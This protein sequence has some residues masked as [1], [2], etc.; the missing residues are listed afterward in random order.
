MNSWLRRSEDF[1]Y[2]EGW[3]V[4]DLGIPVEHA[5]LT[6]NGQ[7]VEVTWKNP[8]LAYYGVVIDDESAYH[9]MALTKL[10][11]ILPSLAHHVDSIEGRNAL[12]MFYGEEDWDCRH[13]N[14]MIRGWISGNGC[15]GSYGVSGMIPGPSTRSCYGLSP[16]CS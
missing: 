8:G 6:C 15:P 14:T 5:W 10:Y 13:A 2:T 1:L 12:W 9:V 7:A 16:H 3:A 4:S 11:G